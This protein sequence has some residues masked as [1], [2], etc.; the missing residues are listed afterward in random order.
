[1]K[2]RN[3][4]VFFS[5]S[6]MS[7]QGF[8]LCSYDL[9]GLNDSS[10]FQKF[11]TIS[12]QKVSYKILNKLNEIHYSANNSKLSI[13]SDEA[14]IKG[15]LKIP[16]TGLI[17]FEFNVDTFSNE[18][19][20]SNNDSKGALVHLVDKNNQHVG[21][22]MI[23]YGNNSAIQNYKKP[24]TIFFAQN[25]TNSNEKEFT[26]SYLQPYDA[27]STQNIGIYINQKSNQIGV[28]LNKQNLGYVTHI[29][30]NVNSVAFELQALISGFEANSPYLNKTMS[31][32]LV[33]DKSKFTNTFPTGTTDA[34]GS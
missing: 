31:L 18:L 6:I 8:A 4:A 27:S 33:T 3:L 23:F 10:S 21:T 19:T 34:C 1:M 17:G 14:E 28:I 13:S 29:N 22:L 2:K 12:N 20:G 7:S 16:E 11:P 30:S 32:E 26:Y 24:V 9:E 25:K 15:T 5:L